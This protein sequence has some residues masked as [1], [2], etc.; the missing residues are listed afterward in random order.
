MFV[1]VLCVRAWDAGGLP[2]NLAP[3][4]PVFWQLPEVTEPQVPYFSFVFPSHGTDHHHDWHLDCH[5][6]WQSTVGRLRYPVS[7]G[8]FIFSGL[9]GLRDG[10]LVCRCETF[11]RSF[12]RHACLREIWIPSEERVKPDSITATI[13]LSS[14]PATKLAFTWPKPQQDGTQWK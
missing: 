9:L 11:A 2:R 3:L 10:S 12:L 5:S 1:A 7:Q 8:Y 13:S 6:S 14:L 4:G